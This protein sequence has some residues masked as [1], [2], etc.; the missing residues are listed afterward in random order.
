MNYVIGP[1]A[2][3]D[4]DEIW[5]Y[6]AQDDPAAADRVELELHEAMQMLAR[7]PGLGHQ[8]LD[9]SPRYRFWGVRSYV[10]AYRVEQGRV[11][12]DR[13]LHGARDIGR[14]LGGP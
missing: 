11:H 5:A 14:L 2:D 8:R 3:A 10:I 6:I 13:V 9:A 7:L 12:V 1:R 4:F